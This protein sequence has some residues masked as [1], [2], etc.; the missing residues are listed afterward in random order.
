MPR[1]LFDE[2]PM[3]SRLA[4]AYAL[5][6]VRPVTLALLALDARLGAIVRRGSEP[7]LAQMRLAWWRD[8]LSTEPASW[9]HGDPLLELL[10][11]WHEPAA[12]GAVVESWEALLGDSLDARS[13]SAFGLGRGEAFA[14]LARELCEEAPPA[15]ACGQLWALADLAANLSDPGERAA[16]IEAAALLPPCRKLPR[17]LRP[18]AVLAGLARRSLARGSPPLLDGPGTMLLAMRLGITGR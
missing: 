6:A 10:S 12:L 11:L 17:A 8:L 15:A 9:P 1:T 7:V 13:I 4:L 14:H 16:A 2:L 3:G 5:P 18:L